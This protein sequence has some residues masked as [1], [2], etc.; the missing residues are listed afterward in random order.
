MERVPGVD[1]AYAEI[2]PTSAV[3]I[4]KYIDIYIH[5]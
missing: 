4:N 3:Y 5:R 2:E 1:V